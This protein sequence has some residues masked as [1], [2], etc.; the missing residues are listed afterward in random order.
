MALFH[1]LENNVLFPRLKENKLFIRTEDKEEDVE[2]D[3]D[4]NAP[5]RGFH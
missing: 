5:P 4:D 3:A 1:R 2:V